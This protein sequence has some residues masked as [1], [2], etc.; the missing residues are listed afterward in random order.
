ME[1]TFNTAFKKQYEKSSKKIQKSFDQR[2]ELFKRNPYSPILRNHQLRGV[3]EIVRSINITGDWRALYR[4]KNET[5]AFFALGTHS[6]L[7]G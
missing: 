3:K 1:I 6:Q 7:Y 2:L 4:E 5:I